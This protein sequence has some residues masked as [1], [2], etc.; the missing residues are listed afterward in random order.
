MGGIEDILGAVLL[1]TFCYLISRW[2]KR[3]D[4]TVITPFSVLAWPFAII[5]ALVNLAGKYFGFFPVN[6][7][8]ILFV[9][10][11]LVFFFIGGMGSAAF[12]GTDNKKLGPSR[13][14]HDRVGQLFD[15]Y[16]PL[17]ITLA[18]VS[19]I[20]SYVHFYISIKSLGWLL[21]ASKEFEEAFGKG[22]LAHIAVLNRPAF[23][24]LFADYLYRKRKSILMLLILM[25]LSVLVLQIKGN[26]IS[27]LLAGIFFAHIYHLVKLNWRKVILYTGAVY[28]LFNL[29]YIIGF[30]RIGISHAYSS[31]VQS[32]LLNHFF[33]YLFAGPIGF[34]EILS[35]P[36]YPLYTFKEIFAVPINLYNT[37]IGNPDLVGIIFNHWIPI[38]SI[39]QYFHLTNV[40]SI[41]GVL[42]M[43]VGPYVTIIYLFI[44][45]VVAYSLKVFAQKEDAFVGIRLVYAFL[46][47]F[48][49]ISFFGLYFNILVVYEGS[50]FMLIMPGLYILVKRSSKEVAFQFRQS[51]VRL[52]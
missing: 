5:V 16:R 15:L 26:I 44:L 12:F 21:I 24:F 30:S 51:I 17:F 41:F 52:Q 34:S 40:F 9:I 11:C 33:T 1:L 38:S 50:F 2:E 20:A 46:L 8:S 18:I 45:G 32:Y 36:Y 48:L 23:I 29:S 25:F 31:Q 43:Y 35:N 27:I 47:S 39:Y 42:Y 19:I 3:R 7:K 4:G 10:L 37:L 22:V 6:L 28:I 13:K 49:A 14:I